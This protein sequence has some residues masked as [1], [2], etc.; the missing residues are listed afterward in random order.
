[1]RKN[2]LAAVV[3]AAILAAVSLSCK[4]PQTAI[5][6]DLTDSSK[7][8]SGSK[9]SAITALTAIDNMG[10]G[11]NLGNT[12]DKPSHSTDPNNIKP[13]IDLY[14]NAGMRHMRIPITWMDEFTSR[15][16]DANGNLNTNH[17][18]LAQL[19]SVVD[20]ALGKGMYVVINAHHE[21]WLKDSYDGSSNYNTKFTTLWTGI[22][23]YFKNK[24]DKLMFEVLNEPEGK[25]GQWG[26]STLPTNS[27]AINL[28]RQ[29]NKVGYDAIRAT[30]GNN[31][32]RVIMIS[33]NGQAN[34]GQLDDVYPA[35]A[36]LPGAGNDLYLAAHVHSYDPWNFCGQEGSNSNYPGRQAFIN[37]I[38]TTASHAGALGIPVNYG[39]FGAGR[40][41]AT[42]SQRDSWQVRE[43][44]RTMR[45]TMLSHDMAPT[46]W[47][48]RGWFS[49]IS[50]SGSSYNF[51]N[52]IVPH[53]MA[54]SLLGK[55]VILLGNNSKFVDGKSGSAPMWC[56]STTIGNSEE[57]LIE[58]RGNGKV[59]L[60][61][62][63][64]Y[65]SSENGATTGMN[66]NR[67]S[68]GATEEFWVVYLGG[69]Q[70]ALM[71]NNQKFVTS[72]NGTSVMTT[73]SSSIG[74]WEKFNYTVQ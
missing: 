68:V 49:L 50:G 35:K 40:V 47:D 26:T 36:G 22:A 61:S 32:T 71:G 51:V 53:M 44:Y 30:G 31:A 64:F 11:F 3:A 60:K 48:D 65:T 72:A 17:T 38:N 52:F 2:N 42:V 39:E 73:T 9:V 66:C 18:R 54:E 69:N 15:L 33:P 59:A 46:V 37:D 6:E 55:T 63:G 13:I 10:T 23:N 24:S 43:Y 7:N 25:F 34:D 1:M 21:H 27:T 62:S 19:N 74:G 4:K 67:T 20:Y 14:Y 45:T 12:F 29:I 28:T 16:A 5:P 41:S 8:S 57:F 58:D 56:N 70:M